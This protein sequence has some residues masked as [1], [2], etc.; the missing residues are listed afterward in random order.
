MRALVLATILWLVAVPFVHAAEPGAFAGDWIGAMDVGGHKLRMVLHLERSGETWSGTADSPDQGGGAL[1]LGTIE[2]DGRDLYFEIPSVGGEYEGTL[3]KDGKQIV[4]RW[5]QNGMT[6][7]LDFEPV[8]SETKKPST[9]APGPKSP[10]AGD[11][12]GTLDAGMKLRLVVHLVNI[13]GVWSGTMDSIDQGASGIPFTV[14]TVDGR[15]LHLEITSING[16]YDGTLGEDGNTITG[17][18]SQGMA[19]PLNL[20]RGNATSLPGPNRPQ[21][22][23]PPFPYRSE[24]VTVAGPGGITLAGTLT[25]P[26]GNGPFPAVVLITGS[27]AQ[28]RDESLM[29]HRPFFVLSD[30]LTRQ[31]IAV[32]RC[33]DRGFAKS[34]GNAETATTDDFVQDALAAV[35]FLKTRKELDAK[36]I[37]LVGH[38][39]GGMIAPIAAARSNDVA[40]VV[41]IAGPG[42]PMG[43]LLVR[44]VSDLARSN[45][46]DEVTV[47]Y[48]AGAVRR[49][50]QI[51]TR[52][53]DPVLLE[54]QLN[55]VAD[56]LTSQLSARDP[57]SAKMFS[58]QS[59][60]LS[61]MIGSTWFRYVLTLRPAET[62]S[63]VKQPVLAINGS[64]D[65]QVSAKENLPAIDKA[66]RAGGNKDVTIDEMPGLNHML[67][68]AKTGAPVEYGNIEETMSPVAMKKISD[69]ILARRSSGQIR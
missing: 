24:D 32:L 55:A 40:F 62:L 11:W 59:R 16:T 61:K 28:D 60:G 13:D 25:A 49:M 33:D 69:W 58:Q 51:A 17:T 18:W 35:S 8:E 52:T 45:G 23:K 14:V 29:G 6:L 44:Q 50:C 64:L 56:S 37:G 30:H 53:T 22:P 9:P 42:V 41:M 10:F 46:A 5:S 36:K 63:R 26:N 39:E 20:T 19:F 67:Q 47:N 66:L 21:E 68:T 54:Q 34:T 2:I 3:S 57:A 48:T 38:S 7:T 4:G 27:G 43:D 31:G 15:K 65:M 12:A 1:P